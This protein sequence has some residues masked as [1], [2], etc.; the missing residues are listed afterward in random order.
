MID[1]RAAGILFPI[2]SVAGVTVRRNQACP[3]PLGGSL[4]F[5]VYLPPNGPSPVVVF[6]HGDAEP[7]RLRDGKEWAQ[8]T[9]WG[10][11]MATSG[12]AAVTFNRR[13]TEAGTRIAQAEAEVQAMLEHVHQHAADYAL[14]PEWMGV[15]VCSAGP[16]TVIPLLF[17]E[18]PEYVRC[19]VVYYGLLDSRPD[20]A[21]QYSGINVLEGLQNTDN[22]PPMLLIRAGR[23][24]P[25]FNDSI[26][27]FLET[28]LRRNLAVE[29]FNHPQGDHAFD[30]RNDGPRTREVIARTIDFFRWHLR[31]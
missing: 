12:F 30:V 29:L 5:D 27:K 13:S 17:R 8:Y 31:Q 6:V 25:H 11:L 1:P 24:R 18:R 19:V 14:Q 26:G 20:S 21:R 15:W 28:A 2:P 9:S 16:R 10:Q 4:E 22:L 23:D 3:N 7:D